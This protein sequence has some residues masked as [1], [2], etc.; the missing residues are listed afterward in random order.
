MSVFPGSEKPRGRTPT[1]VKA[2]PS[3]WIERPTAAGSPAKRRCQSAW[4]S[5]TTRSLPIFSSSAMKVR[6]RLAPTASEGKKSGATTAT[7]RRSGGSTPPRFM[8]RGW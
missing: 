4:E 3:S 7:S 6:P 5:T 2:S 1:T 8:S